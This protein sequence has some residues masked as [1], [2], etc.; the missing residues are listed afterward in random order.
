[1]A[2]LHQGIGEPRLG[3]LQNDDERR[4]HIRYGT[5]SVRVC[6]DDGSGIIEIA[7]A[8]WILLDRGVQS[9]LPSMGASACRAKTLGSFQQPLPYLGGTII[10]IGEDKLRRSMAA[11]LMGTTRARPVRASSDPGG[12]MPI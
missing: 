8:G 6:C 9:T 1:M 4:V 12:R 5:C 2:F 11:L 7:I 10:P 3:L